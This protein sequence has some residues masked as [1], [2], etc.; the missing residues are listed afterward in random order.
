MNLTGIQIFKYLPAA[1]KLAEANCKK[2][3]CATCMA[4]ALK[5]AQKQIDLSFCPC[6]PEDLKEI[7]ESYSKK[8]QNEISLSNDVKIGGE[9]VMFRHEKTFVNKPA[10]VIK[11]NSN[12]KNFDEKLEKISNYSVERVGDVFKIE[13]IYLVDDGN[14]DEAVKKISTKGLGLIVKTDG[15][16]ENIK[17]YN[18][19]FEISTVPKDAC[20]IV[21]GDTLEELATKS[22]QALTTTKNL[23]LNVSTE[24][25]TIAETIELLTKI[26]R[27]A[28]LDRDERFAHPVMT[29]LFGFENL[30][31]LVTVA[32][33]HICRY[34]NLIVLDVFDEALLTTLFTLRQGIYTDPQKPLQVEAKVYEINEPDEN[35]VVLL[36]TNFALTYFAVANELESSGIP[37]YL[38]VTPSDG[39]SVLTAWSADRLNSDIALKAINNSNLAQKVKN[40][41]IIIPGLLADMQEELEEVVEGWKIVVGTK[42]VFNLPEFLNSRKENITNGTK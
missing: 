27:L 30:F 24:N 37:A 35:S 8:Q 5:L 11:L 2:C 14:L 21:I 28:I 6:A 36:T 41:E 29:K 17:K 33:F 10:I 7:F 18:P 34:S 1:K 38:I 26:R 22:T 40:K 16:A 31:E 4:F 3:G 20:A 12:D 19:I 23:I 25:K 13:A 42:E 15:A 39:M 32:A 9:T